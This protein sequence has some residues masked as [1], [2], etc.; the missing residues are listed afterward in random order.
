VLTLP[1][2]TDPCEFLLEQGPEKFRF[3]AERAPNPLVYAV[4]RAGTRFDLN[5][6]ED[7]QR[8]AEWVLQVLNCVQTPPS[9]DHW[10]IEVKQAKVLDWVSRKLRV[11]PEFLGRVLNKARSS[12]AG[13]T[14]RY[15]SSGD[16]AT[17]RN[18]DE[19]GTGFAERPRLNELDRTDVELVRIVLAEPK[20]AEWLMTRVAS[21]TLTDKPLRAILQTCY[22][23][24]A[25]NSE[26][27]YEN[28]MVRLEDPELRALA[29]DLVAAKATNIPDSSPIPTSELACLPDWQVRLERISAV[30]SERNL[31]ARQKAVKAILDETD[32]Q[33]DPDAYRA[34]QLEYRRLLTSS[35]TRK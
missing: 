25:E 4:E 6:I 1:S 24:H 21:A 23:L 22:D 17:G 32:P 19:E 29:T 20:A 27:S 33:T 12:G 15:A 2:G 16:V 35:R 9:R 11:S 18:G 5:S 34:I 7:S 28:L 14:S 8:A 30:I 13:T 3:M 26:P 31:L 10:G